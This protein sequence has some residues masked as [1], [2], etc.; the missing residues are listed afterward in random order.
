MKKLALYIAALN[1]FASGCVSLQAQCPAQAEKN[2]ELK[3]SDKLASVKTKN[4]FKYE[5][6]YYIDTF[7]AAKNCD[8]PAYEKFKKLALDNCWSGAD[9]AE[10]KVKSTLLLCSREL[11]WIFRDRTLEEENLV[12]EGIE[13][14]RY[15]AAGW[16]IK[17]EVLMCEFLAKNNPKEALK[18]ADRII[19]E[20]KKEYGKKE[21]LTLGNNDFI[22]R[23]MLDKA[24]ILIKTKRDYKTASKLYDEV[25]KAEHLDGY[26]S[27]MLD[28]LRDYLPYK[29]KAD[30]K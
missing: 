11:E 10:L 13:Q 6:G 27:E 16:P 9:C 19:G 28:V 1:L 12:K 25:R 5:E 20:A 8:V 22:A 3:L 24:F 17:D 7:I 4:A 15:P 30:K 29:N 18:I 23:A 14:V 26:I 2:L 21:Y